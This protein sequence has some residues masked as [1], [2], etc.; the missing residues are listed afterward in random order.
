MERHLSSPPARHG[1]GTPHGRATGHG[2]DTRPGVRASRRRFLAGLLGLVAAARPWRAGAFQFDPVVHAHMAGEAG[3]RSNAYLVETEHGVVAV[4]ALLTVSEGRALRATLVALG[5]S[6][7]AV[8]LTHGHPDH[9]GGLGVLVDPPTVPVVATRA[10]DQA[11][12]ADRAAKEQRLKDALGDE[13][14]DRPVYP[15]QLLDD[16][17]SLAIDG[18]TFTVHDLGPGE[19]NADSYW[20]AQPGPAVFIGDVAI[21]RVHAYLA[22]GHSGR[23]LESLARLKAELPPDVLLYPGH[24]AAGGHALLDWQRAYV[25]TYRETVRT[26][27]QGRPSLSDAEKQALSDRMEELLPSDRLRRF[28]T[29]GADAVAAELATEP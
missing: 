1:V 10:V 26:L 21:N 17:S 18:L 9:Y 11:L 22:D 20:T 19:S 24:G 15:N 8:L 25:E 28:I 5:K 4:D 27:A 3:S 13:W 6:L 23:W 16:G 7:L 2:R 12:R 29:Q 14:L